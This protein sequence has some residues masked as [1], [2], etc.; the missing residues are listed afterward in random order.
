MVTMEALL[1]THYE[2][3]RLQY[4]LQYRDHPLLF[5]GEALPGIFFL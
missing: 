4:Y 3:A 5:R 2:M 1:S